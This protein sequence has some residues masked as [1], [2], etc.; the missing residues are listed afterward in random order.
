M[1]EKSS[2]FGALIIYPFGPKIHK[3]MNGVSA[4]SEEAAIEKAFDSFPDITNKL[5]NT[6][7]NKNTMLRDFIQ[8][9]YSTVPT[10]FPVILF[11]G[12]SFDSIFL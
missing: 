3:M 9:A 10:K 7:D 11:T 2:S 5:P 12:R 8:Q 1:K 6:I 4:H